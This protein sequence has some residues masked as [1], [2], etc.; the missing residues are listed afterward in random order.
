MLKLTNISK[1]YYVADT[2]IEALKNVELS[3]RENEFVA[4]LGPS[5][6]GKTTLLNIIGGLDHYDDGD[7]IINGRQTKD[8]KEKDWN[9]Y[10]NHRIGFIFQSYNL[11]PHQ[12]V[13]SNVELA[14]TIAGL[15]KEERV[16]KAKEALDKVGLSDQYYK[17]PNQLSGGQSQRVAIAR[18]L[19]NDPEILLADEPTG[20]LDTVTS[21]QIMDL[22][23][24]IA[25]DKLVIMV[26]HNPLL[27][28]EYATRIIN[29]LDGKIISDSNP[30]NLKPAIIK[31]KVKDERAKMSWW[32]TFKLS[33]QNLLSKSNRTILTSIA[34]SIGI[35]GISLVLSL[36]FGVQKFI[37]TTQED[38]LSGNPITITESTFDMEAIM[39]GMKPPKKVDF[40]KEAGYV[41]INKMV[42]MLARRSKETSGMFI[43]N[44]I[45]QDYIDYLLEM[46]DTDVAAIFLDREI[47]IS[48]N[49]YLGSKQENDLAEDIISMTVLRTIY[50]SVLEENE[51]TKA[52]AG[53]ISN[54]TNI[55]NQAPDNPEYLLEQYNI[56][57]GKI[58]EEKHEIMLVLNKDGRISDLTLAQLG[59][60]SQEDF[61][62]KVLRAIDQDEVDDSVERFS[63]EELMNK[64]FMWYPNDVVFTRNTDVLTAQLKPFYYNG[65]GDSFN[66]NEG[67]E[68]EVVGILEPKENISYG[69]L[70]SGFYYTE[71]LADHIIEVNSQSE[72]IQYILAEEEEKVIRSGSARGSDFGITFNYS[73][74]YSGELRED[75]VG[76]VGKT[77]Q[78]AGMLGTI[79]PGVVD[80]IYLLSTRDLGGEQ[81]ASKIS[82][83][84]VDL[85]QKENVINYLDSWNDN[86][87][88]GENKVVYN[89]ALSIVFAMIND[90]VKII[91]I[92]LIGFTS[93]ALFVSSVMIAIIT[94]VSVVERTKEIGVIR[95]LGGS[96]RDVSN[97]FV[98]ETAIIGLVS[99]IFA[100][101]F[102]YLASF[103]I[104]LIVYNSINT[105]IAVFPYHFALIMIGVSIT[106][107]LI[108][109]LVPSRSAAKKDPVVALRT[110]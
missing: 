5:G 108:S 15:P 16:R 60:Y 63:Y 96:K 55:I 8:F 44:V 46:P 12:T 100:I 4:V 34:S 62:N 7:L 61:I 33:V 57:D 37:K 39:S 2:T 85:K 49:F 80:K 51:E 25:Q 104:N 64:S 38:M 109:G 77:D 75:I 10:R 1:N 74:K 91:T 84:P 23:K 99:G 97:L 98:A 78:M 89:D 107:T 101:S 73:Y 110:E 79:M 76:Y 11:I 31:E 92:A 6:S 21:K 14:L 103:I 86:L 40:I 56:L 27:A 90:I 65:Y 59:Y 69:S 32:T 105:K 24:E 36:S 22:I 42:E 35:I 19:V 17:R 95:S 82:I 81:I 83:Y 45:T 72:V 47:D 13:L 70:E 30:Y 28:E 43:K 106:L 87:A 66:R 3:L 48:N 41:N 93:L 50:T 88:I 71:K 29:L 94:Y 102:T 54:F 20:A 9:I 52:Y 18:A 58:A 67:I 26:T 53:L 68:L